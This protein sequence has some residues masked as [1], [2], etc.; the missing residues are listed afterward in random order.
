MPM[1]N[2]LVVVEKS[3]IAEN[4]KPAKSR[5]DLLANMVRFR[6]LN[7]NVNV[8]NLLLTKTLSYKQLQGSCKSKHKLRED[9]VSA[10]PVLYLMNPQQ[11]TYQIVYLHV[12]S[13]YIKRS[14]QRMR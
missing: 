9:E 10:N 6:V 7:N 14:C 1:V 2:A 11:C 3:L 4:I 13:W 12:Y 8:L 5:K